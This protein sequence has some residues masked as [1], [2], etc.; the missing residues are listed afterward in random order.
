MAYENNLNLQ[1]I[2]QLYNSNAFIKSGDSVAS[3][4]GSQ[5]DKYLV[6]REKQRLAEEAFK[7][8]SKHEL[9]LQANRDKSA[10]I[11]LTKQQKIESDRFNKTFGAQEAERL[12]QQAL[13]EGEVAGGFLPLQ[14]AITSTESKNVV[15]VQKAEAL[16]DKMFPTIGAD[17][18]TTKDSAIR[19]AYDEYQK[20]NLPK[21]SQSSGTQLLNAYIKDV[22][23]DKVAGIP[24]RGIP[25]YGL[26]KDNI[27]DPFLKAMTEDDSAAAKYQRSKEPK[28]KSSVMSYADF[29]KGYTTKIM[30]VDKA[31]GA[32]TVIGN[33][34]DEERT[35]YDND[36]KSAVIK[37]IT[38]DTNSSAVTKKDVEVTKDV[39][40][41][42][43]LKQGLLAIEQSGATGNKKLG[44]KKAILAKV[45]AVDKERQTLAKEEL[46]QAFKTLERLTSQQDKKDLALYK[47]TLESR[48]DLTTL[49][50]AKLATEML[51]KK[52]LEKELYE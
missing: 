35:K 5:L 7:R 24:L 27:T 1:G 32:P 30:G 49:E 37:W 41:N 44:M 25:G 17:D 39:S 2:G 46:K 50:K 45:E 36:A 52:K 21:Y 19:D 8:Q 12:R 51:K 43:M 47:N 38:T 33:L 10:D 31:T 3:T 48:R 28:P 42:D 4:V 40:K 13:T 23:K 9:T 22:S 29:A 11:R 16:R 26:I 34:S 14:E 15:D 18:P 20:A 6:D